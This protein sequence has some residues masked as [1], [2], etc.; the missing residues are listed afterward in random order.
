MSKGQSQFGCSA[1]LDTKL[2]R[3]HGVTGTVIKR[4]AAASPVMAIMLEALVPD[5]GI[6]KLYFSCEDLDKP[7][8][9]FF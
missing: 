6:F 2:S 8:R 1:S 9:V 7:V 3:T 4:G 5:I